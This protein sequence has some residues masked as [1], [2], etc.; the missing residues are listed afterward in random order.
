MDKEGRRESSYY[1]TQALTG[2]GSLQAYLH[3]FGRTED[4]RCLDGEAEEAKAEHAI[5]HRS[6]WIQEWKYWEPSLGHRS[7]RKSW[8][9]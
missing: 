6:I 2:H 5:I 7:L 8:L 1:L 9:S 4:D 3:S